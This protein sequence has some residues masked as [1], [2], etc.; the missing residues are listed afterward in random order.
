VSR[1]VRCGGLHLQRTAEEAC[2][3][4][5]GREVDLPRRGREVRRE[6][7]AQDGALQGA[8]HR[9]VEGRRSLLDARR[10]GERDRHAVPL[11]EAPLGA[12]R[13]RA[14]GE[15]REVG[16]EPALG[17]RRGEADLAVEGEAPA[18]QVGRRFEPGD[19][20]VRRERAERAAGGRAQRGAV[21]PQPSGAHADGRLRPPDRDLKGFG[22]RVLPSG[23]KRYFIHSQHR[24]RRVWKII[25]EAGSIG[26]DEARARARTLLAT[27]REGSDDEI[28]GAPDIA[29]ETVADEVFQR[30]ARNW[31]PSTL[32]VNRGYY[33]NQ[34]LPRFRGRLI[35]G[36]TAHDVRHWFASL[37]NTPVAADRSAPVLSVIMRQAE[38]YGYRPEGTNPCTG[39]KRYRRQGRERFLSTAEVCRLGEVFVRHE[40]DR[41]EVVA[42]IRL[43]LLTGCRTGEIVSLKWHF[44]REGKLFLP[45]SK[46]G[47]RTVWLSSAARAILD[48]LSRSAVWAFPS[49]RTDSYLTA[50]AVDPVWYRVREEADLCDVRLHDLRHTY[51]SMALA[52]GETVLT[53]GRL[54]GHN[55]PTTTL[56][57]I[58]LADCMVREAVDTVCAVLEG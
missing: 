7:L 53:I 16:D 19:E 5:A 56:K 25:G 58:H 36:I 31:K 27:I 40:A 24:G 23:A 17:L 50:A 14:G 35:G 38:V 32:K 20:T 18:A 2:A 13:E 30:Y 46:T 57:Y 33:H 6:P 34:I 10:L 42:I 1:I 43:L 26:A 22:V 11:R 28:A 37:H 9:Q 45:D 3:P 8:A 41:P 21:F 4:P 47:P 52:Q 44:Y 12:E 48:G 51:A 55:D 15:G 49:P 29:F 54:L 39:I